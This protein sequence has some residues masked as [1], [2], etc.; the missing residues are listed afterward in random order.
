MPSVDFRISRFN[1]ETTWRL[2]WVDP[3]TGKPRRHDTNCRLKSDAQRW[4]YMFLTGQIPGTTP[5]LLAGTKSLSAE[6]D[7]LTWEELVR[8]YYVARRIQKGG[9]LNPNWINQYTVT[10]KMLDQKLVAATGLDDL[11]EVRNTLMDGKRQPSTVR[12]YMT[13]LVAAVHW[14]AKTRLIDKQLESDL[15]DGLVLP[16]DNPPTREYLSRANRD[17]IYDFCWSCVLSCD[18]HW[19]SCAIVCLLLATGVRRSAAAELTWDRVDFDEGIVNFHDP[20]L[21]ES[22]KRRVAIPI[23]P[24][25]RKVL[26][27]IYQFTGPKITGSRSNGKLF[28]GA[29]KHTLHNDMR[30]IR[31]E[32][33]LENFSYKILRPTWASLNVQRGVP[34]EI[35]A[36]GLGD[37]IEMTRERYA[38]LQP[39]HLIE[40]YT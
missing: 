10:L 4:L 38:H 36:R 35:V 27:Q 34:L 2:T 21:P 18:R 33:G 11:E 39:G 32:T 19:K 16:Q 17:L 37:T 31:R 14:A 40:A 5:E 6:D 3:K 23:G 12:R 26:Q 15:L 29:T 8:R 20:N 25:T 24:Q 22:N 13:A 28:P 1:D 9:K 30:W 7:K